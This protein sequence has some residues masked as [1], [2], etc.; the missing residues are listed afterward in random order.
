MKNLLALL[1]VSSAFLP[2]PFAAENAERALIPLPQAH[3]H[4]DYEQKRPLWDALDLGF[5]NIEP[6][7]Y[8]IDGQLLV[9]HELKQ[10]RPDRTL[11][12]LYLNPL[13]D[14][15]RQNSGR[16]YRNGPSITLLIDI[17]SD[18][19]KTYAALR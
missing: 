17:N 8:L 14:R 5:C 4:N 10:V 11:V 1:A 7:I 18:A 6:D 13:R 9:A 2:R 16:V 3:S 12:S 15:V 19:A